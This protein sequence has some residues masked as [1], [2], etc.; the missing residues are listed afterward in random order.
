MLLTS[1]EACELAIRAPLQEQGRQ[2]KGPPEPEP[3]VLL[4]QN[5]AGYRNL[6]ELGLDSLMIMDLINDLKR[7]FPLNLY[8][9]ELYAF[10]TIG[11]LSDYLMGEIRGTRRSESSGDGLT[12]ASIETASAPAPIENKIPGVVFVLSSPRAGSC[13]RDTPASFAHRNCTCCPSK[14]WARGARSSASASSAKDWSA[15]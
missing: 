3:V 1:N 14:Q 6:I 13:W 8:P 2:N 7:S 11:A 15:R 12:F 4:C 10:P 9:R 5:E